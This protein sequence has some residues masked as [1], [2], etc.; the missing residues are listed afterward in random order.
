MQKSSFT[1]LFFL[2]QSHHYSQ[3]NFSNS[4]T[5]NFYRQTMTSSACDVAKRILVCDL[6]LCFVC[7]IFNVK[8]AHAPHPN[9]DEII[10]PA[11]HKRLESLSRQAPQ[12]VERRNASWK[13]FTQIYPACLLPAATSCLGK[14]DNPIL[15]LCVC[16]CVAKIV[17]KLRSWNSTRL[18]E[19]YA[20]T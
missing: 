7:L 18:R 3:Q 16:D 17:I 8:C 1:Y 14:H 9:F 2:P 15:C 19:R 11:S 12:P 4:K 6:N 20:E 10:P 5:R 13:I